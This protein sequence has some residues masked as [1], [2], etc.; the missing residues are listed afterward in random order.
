[1]VLRYCF[2][3]GLYKQGLLHDLSKYGIT[4]FLMVLNIMRVFIHL[5]IM[6]VRIRAI[7]MLGC[8]I[9]EETSIIV[10]TGMM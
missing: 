4:E 8:I 10:N 6:S 3:C 2:K 1:M 5:I 7:V 9:K